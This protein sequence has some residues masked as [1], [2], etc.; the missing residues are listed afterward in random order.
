M[1]ICCQGLDGLMPLAALDGSV[2]GFSAPAFAAVDAVLANWLSAIARIVFWAVIMAVI[3]MALYRLVSPQE[4]LARIKVDASRVRREV[5]T[6]DGD[7]EQL[8]PLVRRSLSLSMQQ[9]G[10]SLLPGLVASLPLLACVIWLYSAFAF[11]TPSAG[12]AVDVRTTP[13]DEPISSEPPS[14]LR[15]GAQQWQI[16][17]PAGQQQAVILDRN[18]RSLMQISGV[19]ASNVVERRVWWNRFIGNPAGYIPDESPI[20]RIELVL[21]KHEVIAAG[22]SWMRGWEA[23]F[24][25]TLLVISVAIK[26]VFRIE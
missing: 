10:L 14:A 23:P 18:G 4:K 7:F 22:P 17:W 24:F 2:F 3:S 21:P 1:Q 9:I 25:I 8:S 5:A 16:I 12:S 20:E 11:Q 19:P 26:L 13:Q 6:F 15:Q